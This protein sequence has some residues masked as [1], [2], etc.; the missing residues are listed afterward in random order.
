MTSKLA[1]QGRWKLLW[2]YPGWKKDWDGW[3]TAPEELSGIVDDDG[4][5]KGTLCTKIPCLFDIE[6]DPN[7]H[8]DLVRKSKS[9][10]KL[11]SFVLS[12]IYFGLNLAG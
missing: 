7:E 10:L 12:H 6:A 4:P 8:D 11:T 1:L 9:F 5:Y 3:I 2:G